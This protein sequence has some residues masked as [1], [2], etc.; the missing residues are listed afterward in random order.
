[1][2]HLITY[3]NFILIQAFDK[4]DVNDSREAVLDQQSLD[5]NDL[6]S[7]EWGTVLVYWQGMV[8]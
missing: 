8:Q 4:S 6:N 1:M 2:S 7:D 5:T 3:S